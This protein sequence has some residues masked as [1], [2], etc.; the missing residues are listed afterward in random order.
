[1]AEKLSTSTYYYGNFRTYASKEP[2][3]SPKGRVL[4][5]QYIKGWQILVGSRYAIRMA[6]FAFTFLESTRR[7]KT[8]WVPR[9]HPVA[10]F[11]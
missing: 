9:A 5:V 4:K 1:M 11:S 10:R 6:G 8:G 7:L 3:P 2:F